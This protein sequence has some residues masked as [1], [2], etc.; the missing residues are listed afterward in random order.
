M[1]HVEILHDIGP[2]VVARTT[3]IPGEFPTATSYQLIVILPFTQQ[4]ASL[5][6]QLV[7]FDR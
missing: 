1:K 4:R 2:L 3:G 6:L 7:V 5:Q